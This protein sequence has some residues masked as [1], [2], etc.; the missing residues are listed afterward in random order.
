M[1]VHVVA[2]MQAGNLH[3]NNL[4]YGV[5]VASRTGYCSITWGPYDNA[6]T[7]NYT[8]LMSGDATSVDP[9]TVGT[10]SQISKEHLLCF[11]TVIIGKRSV[12]RSLCRISYICDSFT[13]IP[14]RIN[15]R[16]GRIRFEVRIAINPMHRIRVF[17]SINRIEFN[18]K[19]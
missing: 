18:A 3:L 2:E 15:S 4:N 9:A 6:G 13:I 12:I 7:N 17:E 1:C 5:C 8:F 10:L 16:G 11:A 14:V 19:K